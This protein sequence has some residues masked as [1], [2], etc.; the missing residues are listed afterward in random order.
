MTSASMVGRGAVGLSLSWLSV[1]RIRGRSMGYGSG[2][3]GLLWALSVGL[4]FS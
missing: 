2:P 3:G 4:A 1:A